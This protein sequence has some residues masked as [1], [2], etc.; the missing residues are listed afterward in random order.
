MYPLNNPYQYAQPQIIMMPQQTQNVANDGFK[1]LEKMIEL[2][3]EENQR[4]L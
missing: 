2:K 1:L 3:S 4:L